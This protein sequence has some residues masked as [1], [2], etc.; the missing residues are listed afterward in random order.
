MRDGAK[1]AG[2]SEHRVA[3]WVAFNGFGPAV[4]AAQQKG[5]IAQADPF[6]GEAVD[7]SVDLTIALHDRTLQRA[8]DQYANGDRERLREM[9]ISGELM[10]LYDRE[11]IASLRREG[12]H[13]LA[14]RDEHALRNAP[15]RPPIDYVGEELRR[16]GF[17]W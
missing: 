11:A 5:R 8:A 4:I 2:L 15:R 10:A 17:K 6:T 16:A 1:L 13:D 3:R 9:W 7:A 12:K 14:D